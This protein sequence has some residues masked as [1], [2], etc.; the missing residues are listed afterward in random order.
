M[1]GVNY[2]SFVFHQPNSDYLK[3]YQPGAMVNSTKMFLLMHIIDMSV[4]IG[5]KILVYRY[6]CVHACSVCACVCMC[7]LSV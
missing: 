1:N 6:V 4:C 7:V 2:S 5:D 3:D